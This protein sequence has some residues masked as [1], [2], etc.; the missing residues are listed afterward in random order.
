MENKSEIKMHSVN[1]F[2]RERIEV[3][4][5]LEVISSTEKEVIAK[6]ED[7]FLH[8]LGTG[9]TITKLLP[10]EGLLSVKGKIDGIRYDSKLTKKSFIGKVF[11]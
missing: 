11:K 5:V 9:M 7:S 3:T 6:L 1:I 4:S 10:T 8:I 2:N